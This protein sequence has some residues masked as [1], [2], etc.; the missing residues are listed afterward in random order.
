MQI[1]FAVATF[2]QFDSL[3]PQI[4]YVRAL[5]LLDEL[6]EELAGLLPPGTH[7]RANRSTIEFVVESASTEEATALLTTLQQRVGGEVPLRR[8]RF[9]RRLAVAAV[10]CPSARVSELVVEQA[11]EALREADRLN[12]PMQLIEFRQDEREDQR[13]M[14]E[15]R[16]A[17]RRNT[18]HLHYQPKLC[19]RGGQVLGAEALV[20]WMHPVRGALSPAIF[21]PAAE[22]NGEIR[23]LTDWVIGRAVEDSVELARAGAAFP[24]H[25]NISASLIA[26]QDFVGH[27]LTTLGTA[28]GHIGFEITETAMM[29]D[30]EGALA[31]LHRLAAA[32]VQLA[33]DDYGSSFSSLAYLQRLPVHELKIDQM[34]ISR[35][36]SGA[37]DPLLVRS[38]IDLA[39]ALEMKVTAEGVESAA[40]LALLQVMRCDMVQG[41]LLSRPLPLD[42]LV[43]F[44]RRAAVGAMLP[45]ISRQG[46][47]GRLA[48]KAA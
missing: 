44:T 40:A 19:T 4:G 14:E 27:A 29:V 33:I 38:T 10:Q 42:E 1:F 11:E 31:N 47:W 26:D 41:F 35:L 34:F 12:P 32:G 16:R 28:S 24:I 17:I 25:V 30:P 13:L 6:R 37:R 2:H 36:S 45:A 43:A 15:L 8:G 39:H 21:V 9:P 23:A 22:R 46:R 48:G 3:R 7:L 5:R 18:L 20:R